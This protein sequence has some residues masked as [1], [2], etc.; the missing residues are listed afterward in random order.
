MN[1]AQQQLL[2]AQVLERRIFLHA[3]VFVSIWNPPAYQELIARFMAIYQV[4]NVAQFNALLH[5]NVPLQ[6]FPQ[7]VNPGDFP[8]PPNT[9]VA[10]NAGKIQRVHDDV[11]EIR[12]AFSSDLLG[13]LVKFPKGD[14]TEGVEEMKELHV[15]FPPYSNEEFRIRMSNILNS[16]LFSKY[17]YLVHQY[18]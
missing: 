12:T 8:P 17:S 14:P 4:A 15:P 2:P 10:T 5:A 16:V 9:P 3:I 11:E 18:Q 13:I 1:A 6:F 7:W